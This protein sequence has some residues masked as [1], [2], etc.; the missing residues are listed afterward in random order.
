VNYGTKETYKAEG[1]QQKEWLSVQD[2]RVRD[3]HAEADSQVVGIDEPFIVDGEELD[4]PGD[5][6]GSAENVINERCSMVPVIDES[7]DQGDDSGT[8]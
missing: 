6:N 2:D 5:P 3:A 4:Y 8:V 1:V 7:T